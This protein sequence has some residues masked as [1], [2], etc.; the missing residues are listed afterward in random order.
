MK[1]GLSGRQWRLKDYLEFHRGEGFIRIEQV[2]Q[3]LPELYHLNT[4]P[5]THDKCAVLSSD[6][7]A[8]NWNNVDS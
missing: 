8:I 4:N 2:C 3:D 5:Y 7:R 1:N 6:V